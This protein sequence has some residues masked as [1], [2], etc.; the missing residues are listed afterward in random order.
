MSSSRPERRN[1]LA[2]AALASLAL[3]AIAAPA[4][5]SGTAGGDWRGKVAPAVLARAK[6]DAQPIAVVLRVARA[7]APPIVAEGGDFARRVASV[8]TALRREAAVSQAPLAGE[9]ERR[10]IAHRRFWVANAIVA[11]LDAETLA[12]LAARVEVRAVEPAWAIA[13]YRPESARPAP[14][15]GA[16][17]VEPG[18]ATVRAPEVWSQG[19]TGQGVVIAGQDTGYRWDHPALRASYRGWNGSSASHDHHWYDAVRSPV[20]LGPAGNAC[21]FASAVP[22]DDGS[23]GTHTMGTMV[24]DDGLGNQIGVAPGARW[25]GCRNMDDGWGTP[26]TYLGCMQWFMA[27]T[28]LAGAN[29]DPARAPHLI[30]NSW[31]CPA[32]EGCAVGTLAEAVSNLR[33]AGILFVASA[34]NAGP[35]CSTVVDPPAIYADSLSV[36]AL[37]GAT[38]LASFSSRG[39]VLVDGSGRLK[40]DLVAPGTGVRSSVPSGYAVLSG[41]SMAAPHVAGVAALMM[42]ANPA[43]RGRPAAVERL[44]KHSAVGL[45]AGSPCAGE[46]GNA[47]PNHRSGYGRV[48]ALAAVAAARDHVHEDSFE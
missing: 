41:T 1:S 28:D 43:L 38:D 33:A 27:P 45:S 25:I 44:L 32:Q 8:A 23:H 14:R 20:P 11:E 12:A 35:F 4:S 46:A 40:P 7:D 30:S 2:L 19:F 3:V 10:G 26:A 13:A 37:Q 48:D 31:V 21:G 15:L 18:I 17:A 5:G 34:G 39:P 36:G 29:P 42:S 9:L 22:C 16:K 47:L 6:S 24:G